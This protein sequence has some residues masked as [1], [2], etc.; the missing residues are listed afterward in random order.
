MLAGEGEG[1]R[2]MSYGNSGNKVPGRCRILRQVELSS[3]EQP[4][5]VEQF[6]LKHIGFICV[7]ATPGTPNLIWKERTAALLQGQIFLCGFRRSIRIFLFYS[8][9]NVGIG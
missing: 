7:A 8:T 2:G 6:S 3:S 1:E 5:C 4:E 9:S